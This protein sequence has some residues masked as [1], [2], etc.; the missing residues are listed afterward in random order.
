MIH[1]EKSNDVGDMNINFDIYFKSGKR[2]PISNPSMEYT[3]ELGCTPLMYC[4]EK[5]YKTEV[6]P[7]HDRK[8]GIYALKTHITLRR[9]YQQQ[10][11]QRWQKQLLFWLVH[12]Y[13]PLLGT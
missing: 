10:K 5:R 6:E 8:T 9:E 2:K 4:A 11:Q 3:L 13:I 1:N 7:V 12:I